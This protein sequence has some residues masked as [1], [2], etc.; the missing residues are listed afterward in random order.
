MGRFAR[1]LN[2]AKALTAPLIPPSCAV[3]REP[4][5]GQGVLCPG[6]WREIA[7]LNPGGCRQCGRP[8]LGAESDPLAQC[9][10]CIVVPPVWSSGRAVFRYTDGGRRLVLALKHGDRVETL[11]ILGQWLARAGQDLLAEAD[12]VVPVPLHWQRRLKRRFNQAAG[13]ALSACH[14]AG[15][16]TS[17]APRALVR[18]RATASQGHHSRGDRSANVAGAFRPAPQ[19]ARLNGARV[20][21]IDDVM[22]TGAT[23]HECARTCLDAGAARVDVL[24]LA[25][26]VPDNTSYIRH[27]IEDEDDE[28]S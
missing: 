22:T 15:R 8:V 14:A 21:L 27:P 17:F 9:D 11:P 1:I 5:T 23:L 7:F 20:V 13:L 2:A 19:A 10:D 12:V 25:L 24:V 18:S 3:C 26:V 28:T 16:K 6:C 4:V